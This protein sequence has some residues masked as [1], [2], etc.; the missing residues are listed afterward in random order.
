MTVLDLIQPALLYTANCPVQVT[1]LRSFSKEN[2]A[3]FLKLKYEVFKKAIL[4]GSVATA[5]KLE[6]VVTASP[7]KT[8]NAEP[9]LEQIVQQSAAASFEK[10][11]MAMYPMEL[12]PIYRQRVNDFTRLVN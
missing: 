5:P 8:L 3:N 6:K 12:H 2:T 9:L 1:L 10:E 4:N 11:T 7:E